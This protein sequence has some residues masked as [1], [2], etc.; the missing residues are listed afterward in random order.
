MDS[1]HANSASASRLARRTS[2][3]SLDHWAEV[4]LDPFLDTVRS[5][6]A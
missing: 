4:P 5:P 2:I 3:M 6:V 1:S